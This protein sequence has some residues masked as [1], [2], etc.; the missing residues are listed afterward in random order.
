MSN[1]FKVL[2]TEEIVRRPSSKKAAV[3]AAK[4]EAKT[5]AAPVAAKKKEAAKATPAKP[6]VATKQ[7][8][9]DKHAAQ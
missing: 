7:N 2:P 1:S 5:E 6:R 3:A 8:G 9:A 4:T